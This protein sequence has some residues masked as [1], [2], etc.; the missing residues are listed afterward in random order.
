MLGEVV[1]LVNAVAETEGL[2]DFV[3]HASV[4]EIAEA[5]G[6]SRL[7]V[8]KQVGKILLGKLAHVEESVT[9]GL[10]LLLFLGHLLLLDVDV[11]LVRQP[12]QGF[13]VGVVFMLH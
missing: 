8:V 13:G 1:P 12:V 4:M 6:A 11:V 2:D 9:L 3:A 5:D 10:A 7:V